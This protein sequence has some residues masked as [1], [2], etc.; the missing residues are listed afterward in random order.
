MKLF[1]LSDL[2]LPLANNVRLSAFGNH[3]NDHET[4]MAQQ[5][6]RIINPEDAILI[7]GD[8][9]WANSI[10][11]AKPDFDWLE[12]R[13]GT[14]FISPGNHDRW[15]K[16]PRKPEPGLPPSTKAVLPQ[17]QPFYGGIIA[18][19][20]GCTAPGDRFF[21]H[22]DAKRWDAAKNELQ[23]LLE[24]MPKYAEAFRAKFTALMIHYPPTLWDGTPNPLGELIL[25]AKP[26]LCVYG[27]IHQPE[28]WEKGWHGT[29]QD[30]TFLIGSADANDFK[31]V[32][33][34]TLK[35][36]LKLL[37]PQKPCALS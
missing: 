7:P 23:E 37:T 22:Y 19:T 25:K 1:L 32:E 2:H 35:P 16:N 10:N 12:A 21:N 15:W 8:V 5:W 17:W 9:S 36:T 6:D 27:H 34:G 33:V 14:K 13:P 29:I 26:T 3:W 4:K 24:N 28:E 18:A 30:T 31:P 11:R 20:V